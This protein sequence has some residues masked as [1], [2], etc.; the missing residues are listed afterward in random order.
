MSEVVQYAKGKEPPTFVIKGTD[1]LAI[2]MLKA[3]RDFCQQFNL[4]RQAEEVGKA[5]AE[6][7]VWQAANIEKTKLPDHD[8][9]PAEWQDTSLGILR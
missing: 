7:A 2:P 3:Y 8:H 1:A 6:M 5:I 9:V 4:Y